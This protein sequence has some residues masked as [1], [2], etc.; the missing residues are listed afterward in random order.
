MCTEV[1]LENSSKA[2]SDIEMRRG[3]Q[4]PNLSDTAGSLR[5]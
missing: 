4:D 2:L 1:T 5:F 3:M